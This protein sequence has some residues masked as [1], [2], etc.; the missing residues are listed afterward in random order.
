ML[1]SQKSLVGYKGL[2]SGTKSFGSKCQ[3]NW[4]VGK[5]ER[6]PTVLAPLR[7][8]GPGVWN[9]STMVNLSGNDKKWR[10]GHLKFLVCLEKLLE[11]RGICFGLASKM[12]NFIWR[13]IWLD[14]SQ[15]QLEY[16]TYC[17]HLLH[18]ASSHGNWMSQKSFANRIENRP[19]W[20]HL[21]DVSA[22]RMSRQ[23]RCVE[24]YISQFCLQR[25]FTKPH[26]MLIEWLKSLLQTELKTGHFGAIYPMCQQMGWVVSWG[27]SEC[28]IAQFCLQLECS[29]FTSVHIGSLYC[30]M[31]R[32]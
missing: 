23:L 4:G 10:P 26:H 3:R 32:F 29:V 9:F 6:V 1:G 28:N 16:V 2:L 25:S 19:F 7:F 17:D 5:N 31:K 15:F 22:D 21:P 11:R 24:C 8:M 12:R 18:K 20:S 14:E 27:V 13:N 30:P